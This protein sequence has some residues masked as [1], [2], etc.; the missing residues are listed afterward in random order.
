MFGGDFTRAES[1][2]QKKT[3]TICS[4]VNK[5][6]NKQTRKQIIKQTKFSCVTLFLSLV[7]VSYL[8]T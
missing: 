4:Q 7:T 2:Y 5:Q 3:L 8:I 1:V 6:T